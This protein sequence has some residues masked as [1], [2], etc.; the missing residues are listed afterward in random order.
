VQLDPTG[1]LRNNYSVEASILE[2]FKA[3]I[4]GIKIPCVSTFQNTGVIP[5]IDISIY[6]I[7]IFS[8]HSLAGYCAGFSAKDVI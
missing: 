6:T 4:L 5:G 8:L 1:P 2:V 3:R 7:V